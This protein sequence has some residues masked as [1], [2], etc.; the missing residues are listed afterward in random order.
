MNN[1]D[2]LRH[3][4]SQGTKPWGRS[5][6]MI[7]GDGRAGKTALANSIMGEEF[8]H[9]ESTIGISQMTCDVKHAEVGAGSWEEYV[10]P[11]NELEAALAKIVA[12]RRKGDTDDEATDS[13][14]VTGDE[15]AVEN[16]DASKAQPTVSGA[17]QQSGTSNHEGARKSSAG[18][19]NTD[20]TEEEGDD[21]ATAKAAVLVIDDALVMKYLANLSDTTK[22]VISLFD[23]GGQTVFNV[24]HHLFLTRYGVYTLVFN[25]EQLV[26]EDPAVRE[27]CLST[28]SFWLNSIVVHTW[29]TN[30]ETMAPMVI[31][32]THKDIVTENVA[33]RRCFMISSAVVWRGRSF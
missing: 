14:I 33:F 27:H 25:M 15:S 5:K 10:K 18:G 26:S 8:R 7:V 9:T 1:K 19:R 4:L 11:S 23:Y 13:Q 16:G 24:I 2:Y 12:A 30:T 21:D 6:I 22:F 20:S 17:A 3:A 32:G 29:D 31:V 28:I